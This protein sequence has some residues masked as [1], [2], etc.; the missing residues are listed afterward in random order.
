MELLTLNCRGTKIQ[1]DEDTIK[2]IPTL[3]AYWDI[4]KNNG[5]TETK[6]TEYFLN[7]KAETFHEV[8]DII[9]SDN[10]VESTNVVTNA[11]AKFLCIELEKIPEQEPEKKLDDDDDE[12]DRD[13]LINELI[14]IINGTQYFSLGNYSNRYRFLCKS[15]FCH[16]INFTRTHK[17][18]ELDYNTLLKIKKILDAEG[19]TDNYYKQNEE[20]NIFSDARS[21]NKLLKKI[22]DSY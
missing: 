1:I 14:N 8:L 11:L 2:Q 18:Y 16:E 19:I 6:D 9:L 15:N 3:S 12:V 4:V 10:Y 22:L 21:K 17:L 13:I 7:C 5:M 20:Q